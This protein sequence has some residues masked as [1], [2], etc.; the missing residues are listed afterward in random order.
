MC[1]HAS[2]HG[3]ASTWELCRYANIVIQSS[4][5]GSQIGFG[6]A[7]NGDRD[8]AAAA[9]ATSSVSDAEALPLSSDDS[10]SEDA[11]NLSLHQDVAAIADARDSEGAL[12]D[13]SN[14]ELHSFG[15]YNVTKLEHASSTAIHLMLIGALHDA[16]H[17]DLPTRCIAGPDEEIDPDELEPR[18]SILRYFLKLQ[19]D[20]NLLWQTS[21]NKVVPRA[22]HTV[23]FPGYMEDVRAAAK[24]GRRQFFFLHVLA[25]GSQ[26]RFT[27]VKEVPKVV[28]QPRAVACHHE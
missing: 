3:N 14:S 23:D 11:F 9:Q 15:A 1:L 6:R 26:M 4:A 10:D 5:T 19:T 22:C 27:H 20:P 17:C 21:M 12:L 7:T 24:H 16:R 8:A 2:S 28:E 25:N 13:N 18:D